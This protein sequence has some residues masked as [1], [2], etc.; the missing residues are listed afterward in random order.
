MKAS[1]LDFKIC[2]AYAGDFE[3][4]CGRNFRTPPGELRNVVEHFDHFCEWKVAPGDILLDASKIFR[5]TGKSG[6]GNSDEIFELC[7][8]QAIGNVA[9]VIIYRMGQ[10]SNPASDRIC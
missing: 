9:A 10:R 6:I 2:Q 1:V 3:L 7:H 8:H 5:M 4:N